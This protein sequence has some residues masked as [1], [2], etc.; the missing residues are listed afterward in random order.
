MNTTTVDPEP[1][2]NSF[3]S[4]VFRLNKELKFDKNDPLM[5]DFVLIHSPVKLVTLIVAIVLCLKL[6]EKWMENKSA[7]AFAKP[8]FFINCGLTFGINGCGVLI[9]IAGEF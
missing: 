3:E 2:P 1:D 6:I 9:A 5:Q 4:V 8:A 7:F